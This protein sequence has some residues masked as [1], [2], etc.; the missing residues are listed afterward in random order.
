MTAELLASV[1]ITTY[2]RADALAVSLAALGRQTVPPSSYE[3]LVT[4]D[5]S[6]DSTPAV[7]ERAA[8]DLPC[9]LHTF[10]QPANAGI[11][12]SRNLA[13]RHAAGRYVVMVSDDMVVPEDFLALHVDTLE[14]FPRHWV[15]G[16]FRQLES[17]TATP[18]GRYLDQLERGFDE[19]RKA[20][21]VAPDVWEMT[22]PTAR[23]MSLPRQ[24]LERT[25][26]FDE[27]FRSACED[28]DLAHQA[29]DIGIGF[30]YNAAIE[31]IH[32]DQVADL[33]RFCRQQRRF[34]HDGVLFCAKRP[35]VHGD[36][37]VLR[38]NRP[39]APGDGLALRA[40]KAA[41]AALAHD[42]FLERLP[43]AV[44][45]IE[46]LPL[47][48]PVLFRLYRAVSSLYILRGVRE[49]LD[50]VRRREGNEAADR[51]GRRTRV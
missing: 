7:L 28:Q 17:L 26:L 8:H 29:R 34:G 5:G 32:N 27:Q 40:K 25:G 37:A 38:A 23:N 21:A 16:G 43:P 12:A 18:F 1:V 30:L 41:K 2:N 4:D 24:D 9:P 15:V 14:R 51:L 36:F 6:T 33:H 13:L 50:V 39:I 10:R 11:A 19:A 42:A 46:R 47:P 45:R 31:C 44:S 3:I 49:G 35:D 20:R 22:I 48:D